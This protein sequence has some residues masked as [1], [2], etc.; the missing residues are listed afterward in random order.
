MI[1]AVFTIFVAMWLYQ[2]V[3]QAKLENMF[4]WVVVVCIFRR[5]DTRII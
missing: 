4:F 2:T 5:F 1:G 3:K